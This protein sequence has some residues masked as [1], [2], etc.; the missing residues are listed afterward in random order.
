MT[1]T[2]NATL[3]ENPIQ[4]F[5]NIINMCEVDDTPEKKIESVEAYKAFWGDYISALNERNENLYKNVKIPKVIF[6]KHGGKEWKN[7]ALYFVF[8]YTYLIDN[9]L[10]A[11]HTSDAKH[12]NDVQNKEKNLRVSLDEI[13]IAPTIGEVSL[14]IPTIDGVSKDTQPVIGVS[15][16]IASPIVIAPQVILPLK[17]VN[18]PTLITQPIIG[19]KI[20]SQVITSP[21]IGA[22]QVITSPIIGASPSSP[23]QIIKHKKVIISGG[24]KIYIDN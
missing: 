15:P 20:A 4:E 17:V 7:I 12:T 14:D 10:D 18:P 16:V 11:T 24:K 23:R 5:R 22:S 1:T 2:N 6:D 19:E 9:M 13:N 8:K 3:K 21:I